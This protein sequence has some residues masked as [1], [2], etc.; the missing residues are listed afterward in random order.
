[1]LNTKQALDA[2]IHLPRLQVGGGGYLVALPLDGLD[3]G[4]NLAVIG[5]LTVTSVLSRAMVPVGFGP[6]VD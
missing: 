5:M 1:M 3:L 6:E 2:L 4:L